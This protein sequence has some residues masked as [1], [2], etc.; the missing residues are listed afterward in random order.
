MHVSAGRTVYEPTKVIHVH[1]DKPWFDDQCRRAFSLKQEVHHQWTCDLSQ[2]NWEEF[3]CCQVK[4]NV[5]YLIGGQAS[6]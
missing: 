2:V 6:V 3:V 4:A 5:T 1:K